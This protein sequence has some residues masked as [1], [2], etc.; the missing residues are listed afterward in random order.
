MAGDSKAQDEGLTQ[1]ARASAPAAPRLYARRIVAQVGLQLG[2]V[3]L[4]VEGI[5]LAEKIN[6]ILEATLD[7]AA[8]V[9]EI[10]LLLALYTPDVFSIAL[11]IALLIAVYRV[12]PEKAAKTAS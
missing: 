4:L 10:C 3:L 8:G 12:G 11:P 9:R 6:D 1:P 7:K 5:F 2:L